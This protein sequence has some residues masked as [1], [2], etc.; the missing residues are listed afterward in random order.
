MAGVDG[1]L[2]SLLQQAVPTPC[3]LTTDAHGGDIISLSVHCIMVREGFATA[4]RGQPATQSRYAPPVGWRG[5]HQD[6]WVFEYTKQGKA[7][8]FVLHCSLQSQTGRMFIHAS[9]AN[10]KE[11]VQVLG[12]SL[13]NYVV[14]N[15]SLQT[16][17]WEQGVQQQAVLEEMVM[18][19]IVQPLAQHA[20]SVP[21]DSN[22]LES[23]AP[24]YAGVTQARGAAV[25]VG[26]IVIAVGLVAAFIYL[27]PKSSHR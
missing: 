24:W 11:N 12:V 14:P 21:E 18:Q 16:A 25:S 26:V 1:C 7:N 19:Y 17:T 22:R 15:V 4:E 13:S 9:E 8:R 6:E 5:V 23:T 3:Y 20:E 27:R 10:N 2:S